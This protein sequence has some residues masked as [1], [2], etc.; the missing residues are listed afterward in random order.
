MRKAEPASAA[1]FGRL[2][3]K[4]AAPVRGERHVRLAGAGEVEVEEILSGAVETPVE[5]RSDDE[6]E[7]VV[8]LEGRAVLAA[9]GSTRELVSGDWVELPAGLSHRL[10][11][12]EPG[13]RWLAVRWRARPERRG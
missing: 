11:H 12:V 1:R 3:E 4:G 8:V 7:W 5:F 13:T 10:E 9:G 2:E 6:S